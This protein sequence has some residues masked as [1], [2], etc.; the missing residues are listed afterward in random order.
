MIGTPGYMAPEMLQ[1]KPYG[2]PVDIWAIGALMFALVTLE[3]PFW[4][5]ESAKRKERV[6]NEDLDITRYSSLTALSKDGQDFLGQLLTKSPE[7]RPS[8]DEVLQHR[9][10]AKNSTA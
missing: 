6:I 1:R 8:I 2:F 3:L 9:W 10:F 4:H 5:Q 7:Q